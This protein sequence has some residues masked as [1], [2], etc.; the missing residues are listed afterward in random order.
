MQSGETREIGENAR[1]ELRGLAEKL[2][3]MLFQIRSWRWELLKSV[4][5]PEGYKKKNVALRFAPR[6]STEQ[7]GLFP[8]RAKKVDE[9]ICGNTRPVRV[10][11]AGLYI[12]KDE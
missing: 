8:S 1:V 12:V 7:S 3:R 6:Q 2:S 4:V 11:K 9:F 5:K 10:M